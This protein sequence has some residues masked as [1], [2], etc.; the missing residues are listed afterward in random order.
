MF[1]LIDIK[2]R[3]RY[4]RIFSSVEDATKIIHHIIKICIANITNSTRFETSP[5]FQEY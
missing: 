5:K 1:V 2:K 3:R 4:Y